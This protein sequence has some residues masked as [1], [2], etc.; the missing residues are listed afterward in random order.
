MTCR[1]I[2]E[3]R[4][5]N[6]RRDEREKR[7]EGNYLR[8]RGGWAGM[9]ASMLRIRWPTRIMI[10]STSSSFTCR[11]HARS[12]ATISPSSRAASSSSLT[13]CLIR[14]TPVCDRSPS[15]PAM[16]RPFLANT[17]QSLVEPVAPDAP[18]LTHPSSGAEE[19]IAQSPAK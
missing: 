8:G 6:A 10:A 5:R 2:A 16:T 13:Q 18:F 17:P 15:L 14:L 3:A 12:I 1:P 9:C 7:T 19:N 11:P 4:E